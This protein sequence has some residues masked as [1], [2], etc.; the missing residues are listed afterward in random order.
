MHR[1]GRQIRRFREALAVVAVLAMSA[2]TVRAQAA[3]PAPR[4]GSPANAPLELE[5]TWDDPASALPVPSEWVGDE[6]Q[7][8]FG[9][10]GVLVRWRL[11]S[12]TRGEPLEVCRV[13]LLR[14]HPLESVRQRGTM[15]LA[16]CHPR[17]RSVWLGLSAVRRTL[18]L[19]PTQRLSLLQGRDLARALGRVAAHELVHVLVP[20]QPHA[21]S[22]LM[23][24]RL[25]RRALS[26][27][28]VFF[29]PDTSTALR[30][31]LREAAHPETRVAGGLAPPQAGS[32]ER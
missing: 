29:D 11:A 1:S 8:Q 22:G 32:I 27:G 28:R 3:E 18:G 9:A 30:A 2:T 5:V 26:E 14:S 13:I 20:G 10:L 25:N 31:A 4:P 23:Q 17:S 7:K 15:G 6:L 12:A 21:S 19:H 24:A 16:Q